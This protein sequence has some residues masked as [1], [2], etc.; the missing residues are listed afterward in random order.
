M[1]QI[2]N[3]S[4]EYLKRLDKLLLLLCVC[5]CVFSALMLHGMVHNNV[6]PFATSRHYQMQLAMMA[7]GVIAALAIMTVNYKFISK[8][9]YLWAAAGFVLMGL[10]FTPL[11]MKAAGS[12][13]INWLNLGFTAI[14][15]SEFVK[16]FFVVT[17][18]AHLAK[19]G[20]KMN[21]IP[22][23]I[24]LFMHA[25]TPMLLIISRGDF[26][27]TLVLIL[28]VL[29][30]L[31]IAGLWWRYVAIIIALVPVAAFVFWQFVFKEYHKT[32]I[33]VIINE[34][35]RREQ[36]LNY[37][38]QQY[39]SLMALGSGGLT[40][41]GLYGGEYIYVPAFQTDFIFTYI[42]MVLGFVGC[43]AALLIIGLILIRILANCL[44][45]KD[46]L[47]KYLCAGVF[48]MIFYNTIINVGMCLAV[49]PVIGQTLP[50]FSAGGSAVLSHF[51]AVGLVLSVRTHKDK[52]YHMFY[53]EKD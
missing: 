10:L 15:P 7:A 45:A 20:K 5:A 53:T 36:I 26:G 16:V 32:R 48:S 19:V 17:F 14:Q 9:W 34:E 41:N 31:F 28:I 4:L 51:M 3:I 43:A 44:I 8:L 37:F 2:L 46:T 40:G 33:L 11:G 6:T 42:G 52:K 24:L 30:M 38:N 13:E 29:T 35:V 21:Q 50:F 49:F 39:R 23:L 1:K 18:S 47:G 12:E 25:V 22:H 27:T